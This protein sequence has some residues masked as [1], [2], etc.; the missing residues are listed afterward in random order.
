MATRRQAGRVQRGKSPQSGKVQTVLG[1]IAPE[2][3]GITLSHEHVMCDC[4]CYFQL[5]EEASKRAYVNA[6]VTMDILGILPTVWSA[7]H[8]CMKLWDVNVAIEE[9]SAFKLAGGG[10]LVDTS[11]I[12]LAR[13]PLALARISRA[14]GLNII[15]GASHYVPLSYPPDM[16]KRSED[17]IAERIVRDITIGVGDTG[18]KSGIIGEVGNFWPVTPNQAKVLRASALAQRETGA[19]I[20]IHP[21]YYPD[22]PPAILDI[23]DKAGADISRVIMGH[24]D[25]FS[26][27][28][29]VAGLVKTGCYM[30]F[31]LFGLE[32]TGLEVSPYPSV[33]IL[34]D[35]QSMEMLE[36]IISK[37]GGDRIVI[38]QDV[39]LKTQYTRYGGKGYAHI[40]E[41]IV[42]RMRKRGFTEKQIHAILVDNP[43]NILTFA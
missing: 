25:V 39:F 3:L 18:V 36:F 24:L 7:N 10:S 15:M 38:A 40:L 5:P 29:V 41:N 33:Y 31:D 13:D 23:L 30:E 16:D 22:S 43:R 2:N 12:G 26:D 11:N 35:V 19:A 21:G 37:G 32:N 14:T 9:L 20:L 28:S 42:P 17:S 4:G 8:D 27:K 6:P 1:P 34:S